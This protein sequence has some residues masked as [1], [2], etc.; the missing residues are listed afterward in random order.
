MNNGAKKWF[1]YKREVVT[2]V[3]ESKLSAIFLKLQK[4]TCPKTHGDDL[5]LL[6][7]SSCF[8][9]QNLYS[10]HFYYSLFSSTCFSFSTYAVMRVPRCCLQSKTI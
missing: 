3:S 2:G 10:S 4:S 5:Y 9:M 1:D 6:H 7:W 8:S